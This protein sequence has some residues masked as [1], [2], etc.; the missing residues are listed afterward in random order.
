MARSWIPRYQ[1]RTKPWDAGRRPKATDRRP[2]GGLLDRQPQFADHLLAHQELL[3]LAGDGH[4][5]VVDEF[6]VA[7]DLVMGDLALAEGP[8]LLGGGAF[9]VVQANPGA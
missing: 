7:R 6:D 5:E 1:S 9:A 2:S 8:D 4:R 3:D